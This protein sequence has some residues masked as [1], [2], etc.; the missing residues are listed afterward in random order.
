MDYDSL[1]IEA[2]GKYITEKKHWALFAKCHL[3]R[4]P[5]AFF[6]FGGGV[7]KNQAARV[8]AYCAD[9]EVRTDCLEHGLA[10]TQSLGF[11]GGLP[12]G[13]V[14][15]REQAIETLVELRATRPAVR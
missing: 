8:A 9:C 13:T 15:Q 11:F 12:L 10:D 3:D 7:T 1:F 4:K 5:V 14:S 2:I 6:M